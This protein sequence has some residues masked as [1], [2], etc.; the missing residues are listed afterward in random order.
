MIDV[1]DRDEMYAPTTT[2][3]TAVVGD[4]TYRRGINI[5]ITAAV[6]RDDQPYATGTVTA[7]GPGDQFELDDG[8]V[9]IPHDPGPAIRQVVH[10]HY[11]HEPPS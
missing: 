9:I 11:P 3:T 10:V 2:T 5:G 6:T 7:L 4:D 1:P 8:R